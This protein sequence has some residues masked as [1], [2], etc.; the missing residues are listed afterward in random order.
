MDDKQVRV[1][2]VED[3]LVDQIAFKR[4]VQ[5]ENLPY[6]YTIAG[7]IAQARQLLA[8]ESF[9]VILSDF[10]LGDGTALDV[11]AATSEN[12][13]II[14]ITGGGN[15]L[16][17]VQAMKAGAADY[18]VKDREGSYLLALPL[19]VN[20][21]LRQ[22]ALTEELH[23]RDQLLQGV[24]AALNTLLTI[25][26][27]AAA[28]HQ[29]L[30]TIGEAA[31]V[32][33]VALFENHPHPVSG[34]PAVSQ[35]FEWKHPDRLPPVNTPLWQNQPWHDS[36]MG[37]WY[38]LLATGQ[39][40]SGQVQDFPP[41]ER[42]ILET[43][44]LSSILVAPILIG[45][46]YWGLIGFDTHHHE[47]RWSASDEAILKAMA[48]G[49]GGALARQRHEQALRQYAAEL[50]ARNEELNAFADTV[51]HDLK[52]P[53]AII[54]GYANATLAVEENLS[55]RLRD[56]LE[57]IG[58]TGFKMNR[59]IEALLLLARLS[60]AE[61]KREEVDMAAV[62]AEVLQRLAPMIADYRAEIILPATWP[63]ALGYAPWLEE[64]WVNYI[65]NGLKYGGLPP[66]LILGAT[67]QADGNIHFW[68]QD[69]GSGL[70][71]AQQARLFTP[72][73]RL[74]PGRASGHGL[75][76]SI[77]QRILFKLGGHPFVESQVGHGTTF[78]FT[79][80]G[81]PTLYLS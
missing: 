47:R 65:T 55:N 10:S 30:A 14:I 49:I 67:P 80:P 66:R 31:S 75:G 44:H 40:I 20:K 17:A 72:F 29:A 70:S 6:V 42:E 64:V 81:P 36:G 58:H 2:F 43:M 5:R 15:E 26:D 41:L 50:G 18:L 16:I 19:T 27:L 57:L 39:T 69:N 1:L 62:V 51:A 4:L 59:I 56:T 71:P 24:A 78:G 77:V 60:Q 21:A 28:M 25:S 54:T 46:E 48:A 35:R 11:L 9:E 37:R 63:A 45:A 8:A 12:V 22:K 13:P 3:D 68:I 33:R 53:L 38:D 79:L 7:S 61:V 73:T 52:S 74:E 32:D 23:R 76:L 34:L